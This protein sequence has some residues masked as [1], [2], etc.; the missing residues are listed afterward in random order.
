MSKPIPATAR[1]EAA[2]APLWHAL[3]VAEALSHLE[4]SEVGL[5]MAEADRRS[6]RHG[7]NR[8]PEPPR[9]GMLR[10]LLRQFDNVL[11]QVLCGAAAITAL[12]G[13]MADT[14]VI[15]AVVLI[16]ALVGFLQEGKAEQAMEAV[17]R[18]LSPRA[19][20]LRG[21]HRIGIAAEAL[22]PGDIVLL[23]PGD[24]VPADLRILSAR[25]L[26]IQEAVLTGESMASPKAPT[27]VAMEAALGDRASMAYSG[28]V[29]AAGHGR[30]VVVGTGAATEL[31][32]ISTL[33]ADVKTMET[34]LLRAIT[35]FGRLLTAVILMLAAAT[36]AVGYG[37]HGWPAD[38]TFMAAVGLS[39]AAIPEGLPAVIT[40]ALAIGVRRMARA[41]AIIRRLPAVEALG[42]VTIICTDKTGTLT[43]NELVVREALLAGSAVQ[44]SGDGYDPTG[45]VLRDGATVAAEDAAL[46]ALVEAATLCSDAALV[47]TGDAWA[48]EGDPV[49]GAILVAAAKAG[50]NAAAITRAWPRTDAIPFE[51]EHRF[52]AALVHDH[53]GRGRLVVKGAPEAVL[54]RCVD[55]DERWPARIEAAAARGLRLIA[56]AVADRPAEQRVLRFEDVTDL[57]LLG[58]IALIDAPRTEAI[59]AVTLCRGAGIAVAMITGDHAGTA[60]AIAREVGI[61][62]AAGALTG[63]AL[64]AM[65]DATLANTVQRV[66]VFARVAPAHKLRLVSALQAAGEVVAMTGDGVND[67]PALK[68]ADIGVA[69]GRSGSEAAKEAA[70]IVLADDN[71]ATIAAAVREGRAVYDNLT[72]T[73][74]M[75][76]PTSAG[77]AVVVMAAVLAGTAMPVTAVQILWVNLITAVLLNLALVFEKPEPDVM[78]R[79]PRDPAAP[80]LSPFLVRRTVFVSLLMGAATFAVF[81]IELARANGLEAARGAAVTALVAMQAAYLLNTRHLVNACIMVEGLFGSPHVVGAIAL[82]MAL[83]VLLVVLPPAQAVFGVAAPDALAWGMVAAVAV[84]LFLVIEAEK[85]VLRR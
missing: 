68:R 24:R 55:R 48:I 4:A 77:Q 53:A 18:M 40:I 17:R 75:M 85:A 11:M 28:T 46:A 79:P 81:Q 78:T 65:D 35:R 3:N 23:E 74:L 43:R 49:D 63:A 36:F 83:Q 26:A 31:G 1:P 8:L 14:A 30:G 16:N 80:I 73:I 61:D 21:G 13:H 2:T 71:F 6:V 57:T 64:E 50:A 58:I 67:A 42:S 60:L 59:E 41:N 51:S 69:M 62:T 5:S 39:V 25:G 32:R 29:V 27:P 33:L 37:V 34:P 15:V 45:E 84:A 66:R 76:L 7:E 82:V 56:I 44:F 20:V 9:P 22:V 38:E 47:R 54:P 12:L 70:E 19:S 52:M 10:R 72:K